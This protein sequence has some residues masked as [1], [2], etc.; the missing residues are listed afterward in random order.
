MDSTV[1]RPGASTNGIP[2]TIKPM[3]YN[4]TDILEA[5]EGDFYGFLKEKD[6]DS[7]NLII[8]NLFELKEFEKGLELCMK[9]CAAIMKDRMTVPAGYGEEKSPMET[10]VSQFNTINKALYGVEPFKKSEEEVIY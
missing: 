2:K 5:A 9:R 1:W 6:Y 3:T 4:N 10:V 8:D 7:C